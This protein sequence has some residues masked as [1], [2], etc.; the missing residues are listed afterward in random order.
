VG[1]AVAGRARIRGGGREQT[2]YTAVDD[3]R[4][5]YHDVLVVLDKAMQGQN[6]KKKEALTQRARRDTEKGGEEREKDG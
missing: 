2:T 6:A 4:S 3:P 1:G 5:L